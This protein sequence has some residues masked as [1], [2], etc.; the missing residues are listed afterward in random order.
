MNTQQN[1][2]DAPTPETAS[3]SEHQAMPEE[4]FSDGTLPEVVEPHEPPIIIGGGGSLFIDLPLEKD[5]DTPTPVLT[6]PRPYRHG[7]KGG[8]GAGIRALGMVKV[9]TEPRFDNGQPRTREIGIDQ[10]IEER[11]FELRI[12]LAQLREGTVEDYEPVEPTDQPQIILAGNPFRL[13]ADKEL[14]GPT[15]SFRVN[16][17][18]RYDHPGYKRRFRIRKWR[19]VA[20]DGT[21]LTGDQG[22]EAYWFACSF[23]HPH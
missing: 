15:F 1:T 22:D 7:L 3:P 4:D 8:G 11:N 14:Q 16:R 6:N 23:H 19:L 5:I 10:L 13:E 20:R 17:P 12:W 9:L 21:E 18:Q 2:S